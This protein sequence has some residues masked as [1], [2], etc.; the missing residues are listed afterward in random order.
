MLN[1]FLGCTFEINLNNIPSQFFIWSSNVRTICGDGEDALFRIWKWDRISK[2]YFKNIRYLLKIHS[3][4]TKYK[5]QWD[6]KLWECNVTGFIL[7]QEVCKFDCYS[8]PDDHIVVNQSNHTLSQMASYFATEIWH[9]L[10]VKQTQIFNFFL[11]GFFLPRKSE[12]GSKI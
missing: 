1:F 7:L 6:M 8:E 3:E 5:I 9:W 10:G 11:G 12:T 4:K 2:I